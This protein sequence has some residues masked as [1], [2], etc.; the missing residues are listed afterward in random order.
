MCHRSV[1]PRVGYQRLQHGRGGGRCHEGVQQ[2][3]GGGG[4]LGGVPH[5]HALQ[6]RAQPRRHLKNMKK[7]LLG[8]SIGPFDMYASKLDKRLK[9]VFRCTP[10]FHCRYT[11]LRNID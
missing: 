9:F 5:Q 3:G 10:P 6:E 8:T 7:H 11:P 2:K 1:L 4:A